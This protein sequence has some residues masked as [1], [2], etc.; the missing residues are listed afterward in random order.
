MAYRLIAVM[1]VSLCNLTVGNNKVIYTSRQYVV[2]ALMIS[3]SMQ[4]SISR[5]DNVQKIVS[6]L[7]TKSV[8]FSFLMAC[9]PFN[10]S[11]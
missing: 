1:A 11:L 3:S 6:W 2:A 5:S 7:I 10:V 8:I 4:L 9:V